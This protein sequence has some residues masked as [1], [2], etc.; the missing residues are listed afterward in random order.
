MLS[1]GCSA[2]FLHLSLVGVGETPACLSVP[3]VHPLRIRTMT[4][5]LGHPVRWTAASETGD[6][7]SPRWKSRIFPYGGNCLFAP[8]GFQRTHIPE[9]LGLFGPWL[10]AAQFSQRWAVLTTR[11]CQRAPAGETLA[12]WHDTTQ[13]SAPSARV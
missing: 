4:F 3:N 7:A 12:S 5:T 11:A 8:R 6:S 2:S 1:Q 13:L 9:A 10:V